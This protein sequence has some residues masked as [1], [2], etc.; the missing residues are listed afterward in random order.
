MV[1]LIVRR[2]EGGSPL[3]R[4]CAAEGVVPTATILLAA[5]ADLA[6]RW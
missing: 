5:A 3:A 2:A 6:E 4:F 1:W